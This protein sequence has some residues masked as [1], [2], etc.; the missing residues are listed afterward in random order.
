MLDILFLLCIISTH[1]TRP[2]EGDVMRE[3][4]WIE[5]TRTMLPQG[6]RDDLLTALTAEQESHLLEHDTCGS[7]RLACSGSPRMAPH[8]VRDSRTG[9]T[10]GRSMESSTSTPR[11]ACLSS[12]IPYPTTPR[13]KLDR[14]ASEREKS[15]PQRL[16]DQAPSPSRHERAVPNPTPPVGGSN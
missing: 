8:A 15:R 16:R 3:T 10:S 6:E 14:T 12:R 11:A 1:F 4:Q 5:W 9:L 13:L 7:R 2:A